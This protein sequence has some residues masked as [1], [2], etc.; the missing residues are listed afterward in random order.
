MNEKFVEIGLKS[1][2]LNYI[3]N[4]TPRHY[5]VSANADELDLQQFYNLMAKEFIDIYRNE[6]SLC[7]QYKATSFNDFDRRWHEGKIE[8]FHKLIGKTKK[9]FGVEE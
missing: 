4:E 9:H 2:M 7:E 8:H 5:F 6:I 1:G 3:D